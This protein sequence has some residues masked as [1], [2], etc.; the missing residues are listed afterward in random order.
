MAGSSPAMTGQGWDSQVSIPA[1]NINRSGA[2]R[3]PVRA[4]A[5]RD[6]RRRA[7]RNGP[8][9]ADTGLSPGAAPVL[10]RLSNDVPSLGLHRTPVLRRANAQ[11]LLERR[12]EIADRQYRHRDLVLLYDNFLVITK[13]IP[14]AP[15]AGPDP[16][17][18][19]LRRN[20]GGKTWVAGQVRPRGSSNYT[21]C[22]RTTGSNS[23]I[24]PGDCHNH[25]DDDYSAA[26]RI[27]WAAFS[28]AAASLATTVPSKKRGFCVPQ[29]R[30]AFSKVKARKSSS[31]IRPFST[32]SCASR[33]RIAEVDH[34]E[35][36]DIRAEDRVELGAERQLPRPNA[37][38]FMRSSASQPK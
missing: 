8:R 30:T 37:V 35:M 21:A 9:C 36:A 38:A 31:V 22:Q 13:P 2:A 11:L 18:H 34:V 7:A 12:I 33:H 29:S 23:Q 6:R 32:S 15:S 1:R 28:T 25:G 5:G 17:V 20:P 16:A 10:Q 27:G 24:R 26:A 19:V 14:T 3:V 4:A